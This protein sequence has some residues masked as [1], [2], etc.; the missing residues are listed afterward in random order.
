M[1]SKGTLPTIVKLWA[2]QNVR[3]GCGEYFQ[4]DSGRMLFADRCSAVRA[5]ERVTKDF[6]KGSGWQPVEVEY[7]D[8]AWI[9]SPAGRLAA[10]QVEMEPRT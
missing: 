4:T 2:V 3:S 10:I 9:E 1:T 6:I 5:W 7:I 8:K